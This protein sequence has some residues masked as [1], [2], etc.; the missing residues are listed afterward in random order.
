MC[1]AW[2]VDLFRKS[3]VDFI[4]SAMKIELESITNKINEPDL[5][6]YKGLLIN[7][8]EYCT[9]VLIKFEPNRP[10]TL[11]WMGA[12]NV[13]EKDINNYT[14]NLMDDFSNED[15]IYQ[16]IDS[17]RHAFCSFAYNGL[18]QLYIRQENEVWYP[19]VVLNEILEPNDIETLD[20]PII[21]YRGC[22][23]SE[24]EN[25][26]YG[27]AWSTSKEQAN[28][29]AFQHYKYQPWF[30]KNKRVVLK[31]KCPKDKALYSHQSFEYEVV[32]QPEYLTEIEKCT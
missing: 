13:A 3:V 4:T 10:E 18:H 20:D 22:S 5:E 8:V 16:T 14:L 24:H 11:L 7:M 15:K 32:I 27:Q 1:R 12:D 30:D 23:V 28:Y 19:K 9:Q 25:A 21:L 26:D 29:F 6:E 31:A 17:L 2:R